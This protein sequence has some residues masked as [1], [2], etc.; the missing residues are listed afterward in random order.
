MMVLTVLDDGPVHFSAMRRRLGGVTEKALTQC[1]RRLK[2]NGLVSRRVIAGSPVG[3]ESVIT[4][5]G[6]SLQP[7]FKA[8]GLQ[9]FRRMWH[10]QN[11][12]NMIRSCLKLLIT[13]AMPPGCP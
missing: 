1:L 9:P 5:L 8:T 2:R 12:S 6:R 4:P 7:L 13:P 11:V 3:V 10:Q